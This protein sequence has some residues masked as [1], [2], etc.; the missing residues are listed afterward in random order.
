MIAGLQMLSIAGFGYLRGL[1]SWSVGHF[2]N[3]E[4]FCFRFVV[5]AG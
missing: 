1:R 3:H 2:R 5:D 4:V